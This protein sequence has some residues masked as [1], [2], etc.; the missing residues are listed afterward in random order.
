MSFDLLAP[1]Y[2]WME[3]ICAGGK[4]HDGRQT[5]LGQISAPKNILMLVKAMVAVWWSVAAGF[6]R[7]EFIVLTPAN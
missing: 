3:L 6:L 1:Y 7:H 2:R 5:F 4:L